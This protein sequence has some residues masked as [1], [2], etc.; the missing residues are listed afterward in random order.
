MSEAAVSEDSNKASATIFEPT[1]IVNRE[2]LAMHPTSR[3]DSF[4]LVNA[5]GGA[6]MESETCIHAGS[7]VVGVGGFEMASR[8]VVCYN[9]VLLTSTADLG[10]PASSVVAAGER[11]RR[12]GTIEIG[13]HAFIGSTSLIMP[14][15]TIGEGAVVAA[16]AYV[17][18]DIPPG[19]VYYPDGTL[20][21]RPDGWSE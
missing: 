8:S 21:E 13:K 17:D 12:V 16:G 3:I 10:A 18:C 9:A 2:Q 1:T 19:K 4:C 20:K 7:K 6:V 5:R 15:V 11:E 14:G